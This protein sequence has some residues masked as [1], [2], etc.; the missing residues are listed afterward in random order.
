MIISLFQKQSFTTSRKS[1]AQ[2]QCINTEDESNQST[3]KSNL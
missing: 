3:R 2:Y 1:E